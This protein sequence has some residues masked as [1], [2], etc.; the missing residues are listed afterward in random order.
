MEKLSSATRH[1]ATDPDARLT[2][3]GKEAKLVFMAHALIDNRH[4][5]VYSFRLTEASGMTKRDAALDMLMRR[6]GSWQMSVGAD[7]GCDTKD[8]VAECRELNVIPHVAQKKGWSAMDGRITRHESCRSSQKVGKGVESI[9]GWMKTV[10]VFRRSRYRG[11]ERTGLCG[12]L[13]ATAYNLV[14]MSRPIAEEAKSPSVDGLPLGEVCL[15]DLVD[16]E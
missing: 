11:L 15:S 3:K 7:T 5:L 4:G 13:V 6:P 2:R 12:E 9:C 16:D 14:R 1:N 10:G 8:F